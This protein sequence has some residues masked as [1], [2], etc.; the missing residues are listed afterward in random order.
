MQTEL[1]EA[2]RRVCKIEETRW[3]VGLI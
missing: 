2:A 3:A 1:R